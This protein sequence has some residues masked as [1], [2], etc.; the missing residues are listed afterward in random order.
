MA[1]YASGPTVTQLAL[2]LEPS[3]ER[4]QRAAQYAAYHELPISRLLSFEQAMADTA[5]AIC[6]RNVA[7]A[8]TQR[9]NRCSRSRRGAHAGKPAQ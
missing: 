5:F 3:A 6:I 8:R 7:E 2:A 9:Q 1:H 4:D